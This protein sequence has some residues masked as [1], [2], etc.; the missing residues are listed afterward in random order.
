[1]ADTRR[2][3][4]LAALGCATFALG[5][6]ASAQTDAP[7]GPIVW[8][9]MTQ[10][11]LNRAF[12]QLAYAPNSKQVLSRY[13]SRS[14]EAARGLAAPLRV[15]YGPSAVQ[16]MHVYR[17]PRANAPVHV[18]IHGGAWSITDARD[19]VFLAEV[20]T[21]AGVHFV[22]PDFASLN[23]IDGDLVALVAQVDSALAW[24]AANANSFGGNARRIHLSGHSSGA[25]LLAA[26]LTGDAAAS[27]VSHKA[28][29]A[30]ALLLSGIYDL[31]P[32][33]LS[34]RNSYVRLTDPAVVDALS[35]LRHAGKFPCPV[36]VGH[37]SLDTPEY[38]RQ[39][40]AF[41]NEL[42]KNGRSAELVTANFYNHFEQLETLGNPY[43]VFGRIALQHIASNR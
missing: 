27:R 13:R 24:V 10:A 16:V 35:P 40:Q 28:R 3:L 17:T 29:F 2:S 37:G 32:V 22:V 38:V 25:H 43:G 26:A 5:A 6:G 7:T 9:G 30:S 23:D 19:Y 8:G 15:P 33:A 34:N 12:D 20:F 42:Q 36:V 11:E 14:D 31:E 39:S 21:R 4:V 41:V 18:F 1:M